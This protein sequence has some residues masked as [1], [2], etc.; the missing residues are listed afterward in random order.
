LTGNQ[1]QELQRLEADTPHILIAYAA[2]WLVIGR[3]QP[4]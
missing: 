3:T 4:A 1:L 2:P